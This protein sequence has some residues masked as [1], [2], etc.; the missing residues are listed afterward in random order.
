MKLLTL[1]GLLAG[2]FLAMTVNAAEL[3]PVYNLSVSFDTKKNLLKGSSTIIFPEERK[4]D[5]TP[6]DLTVLS[7]KLNGQPLDQK[8]KDG[9]FKVVLKGTLEI[10]FEGTFREKYEKET[11]EETGLTKNF[12]GDEG[13]CLTGGWFPS[14]RG[15]SLYSLKTVLPEGFVAVSEADEVKVSGNGK[16]REYSFVFPH[17]VSGITLIAGNYTE[18]KETFNG[19]DIYGYFFPGDLSSAKTYFEL[20]K[21]Y[22]EMYEK[23]LTPYPYK[24]FSIVESFL[25]AGESMPTVMLLGSEVVRPPLIAETSL[26]HGVLHQWFGNL[27]Y[28]DYPKGDWS[29]GLTAYLSDH[30]YEEQRGKA[31]QERKNLMVDYENYVNP[32]KEFP[33]GN[34]IRLGDFSSRA[35]GYGKGAMLFHMLRNLTGKDTFYQALK[36]FIREKQ[37]QEASWDDLKTAFETASG[38]NLEWFFSQWLTRNGIP[39]IEIKDTE[40][41]V[42]KGIQT[43]SFDVIQK[44]EPFKFD[45]TLQIRT[46]EGESTEILNI[47]KE[48]ERFEIPVRGNPVEMVF[49]GDYDIMRRLSPEE[50]PP[51]VSRLFGDEKRVVV[52]PEGEGDIYGDLM[53]VLKGKGFALMEESEIRDE[54]IRKNS[55][56]VPGVE[57]PVLKRLFGVVKRPDSG[58]T[59]TVKKNPLNTSKVIAVAYADSKEEVL[60]AVENL[61]RYGRYSLIRFKGGRNIEKDTAETEKGI[62]FELRDLVI[63]IQPQKTIKLDEIIL[64]ILDKPVIYVGERHTNYEDHKVQLKV[65]MSLHENG[66]KFAIGMEMFQKPF[67]K[68]INYYLSGTISEKEFLKATQ[69]FRRW[70]Y[71]YNQYREIIEYARAKNIPVIALNIWSEIVEMVATDGLDALTDLEKAEIPADMDMSDEDYRERLDE[72]FESHKELGSRDFNNFYQAQILWDETM[73]HSI[74]AFL[75][76]NPEYQMVVLAGAGHIIYGSGIPKRAF[77][78]NGKEYVTLVPGTGVPDEDSGDFVLFPERL[79]PPNTIKLGV[80]LKKMN[81]MVQIVKIQP[82]SIAEK[83]GIKKDD[84]ITSVDDWKIEDVDDLRI[85]MFDKKQGEKM[86]IKILRKKFLSGY[87]EL[88]FNITL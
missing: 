88:E 73:A 34:F 81:G 28:V 76:K 39:S 48:S 20:T 58:F 35:I 53:D 45:M 49:D 63:G 2:I 25:P 18:M 22:I 36:G 19:I 3:L 24:R 7:V 44:G 79:S 40:V 26:G 15:V 27:V 84:I 4:V 66:R 67:Q 70:Q 33:L 50:Y 87:R 65:I 61:F 64:K 23:L 78:L 38:K 5:I 16:G 82:A 85:Y 51:V 17:P 30:L 71:D 83:A 86:T 56:L 42:L 10:V 72:V 37:F 31:W 13:I 60:P 32:E 43:V 1:T 57:S 6:G 77:R 62:R 59:L 80:I 46:D 14:I 11:F 29:G 41:V 55:L 52:I 8:M 74:D 69:Y 12:I 9:K 47:E 21:R 68:A 75:K 54:D